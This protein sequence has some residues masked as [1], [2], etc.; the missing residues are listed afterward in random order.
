MSPHSVTHDFGVFWLFFFFGSLFWLSHDSFSS[1]FHFQFCIFRPLVPLH[2]NSQ[3]PN[4]FF[5]LP[6]FVVWKKWATSVIK[7]A[8]HTLFLLLTCDTRNFSSLKILLL[9]RSEFDSVVINNCTKY[10]LTSVD[11]FNWGKGLIHIIDQWRPQY[12][13]K[14]R[15]AAQ[16]GVWLTHILPP[17]ELFSD[18]T[19]FMWSAWAVKSERLTV[20]TSRAPL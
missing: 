4:N 16:S 2:F 11:V 12:A 5:L 3:T 6:F 20:P 8:H 13:S 14:L 17:I 18:K 1:L 9:R 19:L 7:I 10:F 15:S